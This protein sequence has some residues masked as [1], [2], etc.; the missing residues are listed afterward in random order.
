MKRVRS[1]Y[2]CG[3]KL[4]LRDAVVDFIRRWA[5]KNRPGIERC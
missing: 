5:E 2:S 1:E 3:V 4:D